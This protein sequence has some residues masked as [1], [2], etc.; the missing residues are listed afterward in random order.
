MGRVLSGPLE[1]IRTR[2][3]A[4]E[5]SEHAQVLVRIVITALFSSYLGWQLGEAG[6]GPALY[7][8]WLFLIGE[9]AISFVL[10][11][12]ILLHPA[13]SHAR[14]WIGMLA[15][16][17]A[18][19]AVMF[20]EGETA[21]P[22]YAVY[23]WVTIGNGLR[24]GPTYLK[25]ATVLASMSFFVV[26]RTTPYWLENLYLSW[27]L[28]GGL[29]AVPLYFNS[30]LKALTRA[31]EDARRANEAK[32]RFLANMSHEFRTPLNGLAGTCDLM[33][34][35]RLDTEQRQYVSAIQAS[36]RSLL[37]LVEDVLDISAIEAGKV[38]LHQEPFSV[39]ELVEG[40]G[41]ILQP[42][43]R[44]KSLAYEVTLPPALPPRVTGD[45]S[46]LRQ[47]LLN[48]LGNAIKF[49]DD[50]FVRLVVE[51]R[52][53]SRAVMR[54]RFRIIDSGIGIAE[55]ARERLFQAFEQADATLSRRH[56]GTGLGTTIAKGLVEAMGGII[57]FQSTEHRG[58]EFWVELPFLL[59]ADGVAPTAETDN[60][61]AFSDPFLRH[62]ARVE[63]MRIIIADD[64][65]ANRMV[66]QGMLQKAGHKV[67]AVH[68]GEALL[69][70]LEDDNFDVAIAD[71]HMPRLSGQDMLRH[72][73]VMQAGSPV[74]TPV[75]ILS[76][77]VTPDSIKACE[78]AGARAFLPKP[79]VAVRLLD[80]LADIAS[81]KRVDTASALPRERRAAGGA[82]MIHDPAMLE[83]LRSLGLG[84]RFE[85][86]FIGQCF[87]DASRCLD[88]ARKHAGAG[89]WAAAKEQVHALKGVAGNLG[90]V[91]LVGTAEELMRQPA[92]QLGRDGMQRLRAME[93]QLSDGRDYL[94]EA[95][96]RG[97]GSSGSDLDGAI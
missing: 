50:G 4:R 85:A 70:A 72:L 45:A 30:L 1:R 63:P 9:L 78:R 83:E 93:A 2:L 18:I 52:S 59:P 13:P 84:G 47:V 66:L 10:L 54:L 46:H 61:I 68:D 75:I 71:L 28:L 88:A 80:A 44:A 7:L 38:R 67:V 58:S 86:D 69:D 31:I 33:A 19:G 89:E 55:S 42:L 81:G 53:E 48:L 34:T 15:D 57:G 51:T 17:T 87:A 56:G 77:D 82:P 79:L 43:A 91:M 24:Y 60:V 95:R 12:G 65:A 41:L 32:S 90:L 26:I 97:P 14:R 20:L 16:Y 62:R 6:S 39:A 5:D 27:G 92:A 73:R 11:A 40:V 76:A 36:S 23:L 29:I 3:R 22:L 49:T 94:L 21:T 25:F 74:K 35:T 8:T 96:G 64:H 37:A